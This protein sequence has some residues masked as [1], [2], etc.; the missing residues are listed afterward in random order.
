MRLW[1]QANQVHISTPRNGREAALSR[2]GEQLYE[3]IFKNYTKKQWDK[4]PEELDAAVLNRIPVRCS[5]DDRYFTD[6]YQYMPVAGYTSLFAA[7]LD[8]PK[9]TIRLNTDFYTVSDSLGSYEK[10]FFSGPVDQFFR[11]YNASLPELEYR[12]L[13]FEMETHDQEYYQAAAVVN[14]PNEEKF[15]RIVEYKRIFDQVNPRTTIV[16]EYSTS[17]GEP[18]YPVLNSANRAVH[19]VYKSLAAKMR[20]VYFVGRLGRYEYLNMDQAF[21]QALDLFASQN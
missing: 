9:I 16:K 10:L 5:F 18:F 2:V 6:K 17:S 15:T 8:H 19:E 4:Y 21:K 3:K 14:Y 7:M 13:R 12:S 20:N 1:L 11:H